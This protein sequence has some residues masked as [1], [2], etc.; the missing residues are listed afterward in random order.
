MHP[1]RSTQIYKTTNI[2][3]LINYNTIIVGD[4]NTLFTSMD[5]SSEQKICKEIMALN[6]TPDQR[7]LTDIFRTFHPKQQN[8]HFKCTWNILQ[9]RSLIRSQIRPQQL[10]K[11]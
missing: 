1:P 3:E 5:K 2:K 7:D 10:Q 11:D 6:D 8:T 4:F 9:N